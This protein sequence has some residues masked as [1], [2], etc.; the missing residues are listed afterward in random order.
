MKER[1]KERKRSRLDSREGGRGR[2]PARHDPPAIPNMVIRQTAQKQQT[3]LEGRGLSSLE[4][5]TKQRRVLEKRKEGVGGWA[6][7]RQHYGHRQKNSRYEH[8]TNMSL[9]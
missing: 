4:C 6:R 3:V 2:W 5:W 8:R 7:D 1:E 9:L